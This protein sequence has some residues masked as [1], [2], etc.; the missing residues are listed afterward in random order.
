M[1][2]DSIFYYAYTG[3]L[4]RCYTA[5]KLVKDFEEGKQ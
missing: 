4:F 1:I 5:P 2:I 3:F